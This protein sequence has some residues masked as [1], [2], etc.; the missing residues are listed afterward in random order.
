M[1]HYLEHLVFR[2]SRNY[3]AGDGLM[4]WVQQAGGSINA[5]TAARQTM[6]H[7]AIDRRGF[8]PALFRLADMLACPLLS[9]EA[10]S[11]A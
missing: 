7:F 4:E 1:A 5:R 2:G 6:F 8:L 11:R 9:P 10:L 3:A